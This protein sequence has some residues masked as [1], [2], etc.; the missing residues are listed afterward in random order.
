MKDL[1]AVYL[2]SLMRRE[3]WDDYGYLF[4]RLEEQEREVV[5]L[6]R[7]IK[8]YYKEY[9]DV[10]G[11]SVDELKAY[12][13]LKN[14]SPKNRGI[15]DHLF[16]QIETQDVQNDDL[17]QDLLLRVTELSTIRQISAE[18]IPYLQGEPKPGTIKRIEEHL[19]TYTDRVDTLHAEEEDPNI[20]T[21]SFGEAVRVNVR[22]GLKWQLGL[23]NQVMGPLPVG[24]LGHI[25]GTSNVGK[26]SLAV[27]QGAFFAHQLRNS[28]SDQPVVYM[29]NEESISRYLIRM[30][31][32]FL[33]RPL[34]GDLLPILEANNGELPPDLAAMVEE[35]G[36]SH[37]RIVGGVDTLDK[38]EHYIKRLNPRVCFV[39]QG[40][41]LRIP[42]ADSRHGALF[43]IYNGLRELGKKYP[44][45]IIGLGQGDGDSA[46]K[47]YLTK[48]NAEGSKAGYLQG[49]CDFMIGIG[50]SGDP[51]LEN[52]RYLSICKNK[53]KQGRNGRGMVMINRETGR[54]KGA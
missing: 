22:D 24:Y 13:A 42:E 3:N 30:T 45:S 6:L 32:V 23:L 9:P 48:E 49:E 14:P 35:R 44:T 7:T 31:T 47:T 38:V 20:C 40:P 11:L 50:E 36:G 52:I 17:M 19:K 46:H 29:T 51:A 53:F 26:S 33:D 16:S 43:Q 25:F 54:F 12:H 1:N 37:F 28:G 34:E 27:S 39:D 18:I 41:K 10:D 5:D 2:R 8:D 21:M 15:Y 4:L